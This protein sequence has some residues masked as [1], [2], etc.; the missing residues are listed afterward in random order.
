MMVISPLLRL[1]ESFQM[2]RTLRSDYYPNQWNGFIL[3][4]WT[5]VAILSACSFLGGWDLYKRRDRSAVRNAKA[6]LWFAGPGGVAI[7]SLTI[8]IF[9][10]NDAIAD[11]SVVRFISAILV[12]GGWTMYLSSS[13]RVANTYMGTRIERH[14]W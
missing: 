2:M 14:H 5:V 11:I 4:W 10:G 13:E 7:T 12:A 1:G 8:V 3:I 6:I 9:L